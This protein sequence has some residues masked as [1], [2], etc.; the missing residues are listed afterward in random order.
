MR[1]SSS[2]I[3]IDSDSPRSVPHS[4]IFLHLALGDPEQD[5]DDA[6]GVGLGELAHELAAPGLREVVDEVVAEL[7]EPGGELADRLRRKGGIEEATEPRVVVTLEVQ[8]RLRPP[9]GERP[10]D[11]VMCGPGRAALLEPAVLQQLADL[12]VAQDGEAVV[13]ARVPALLARPQ[14]LVR[15]DD[16]RRVGDVEVGRVGDVGH[17]R[18]DSTS[19]ESSSERRRRTGS[20]AP[21]ASAPST[22]R[23]GRWRSDRR[24]RGR[25][26]RASPGAPSTRR[27]P[28]RCGS[29]R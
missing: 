25:A 27:R 13:R 11:P 18:A 8:E 10:G 14:H 16:E 22:P 2:L 26:R 20:R 17:G 7:P 9:V 15:V 28:T 23:A 3:A 6:R 12:V 29:G 24:A 4:A 19:R 5:R 1:G 21:A